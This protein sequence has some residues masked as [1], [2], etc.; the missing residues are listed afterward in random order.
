MATVSAIAPV[1]SGPASAESS[2]QDF[3]YWLRTT[4]PGGWPDAL[5]DSYRAD[6]RSRGIPVLEA[7]QRLGSIADGMSRHPEGW[8][9]LFNRVYSGPQHDSMPPNRFLVR[10][11]TSLI[12]G[13]ALDVCTGEGR[14]A[15]WLAS[16]GW[17]VTGF[18]VAERGL[19]HAGIAVRMIQS[20]EEAFRYG[21]HEWDLIVLS[22]APVYVTRPAFVAKLRTALQPGG[23]VV[24]ESFAY[25]PR[26]GPTRM[27]GLEIDPCELRH[28]FRSFRILSLDVADTVPDWGTSAAPVLRL[29]AKNI[30]NSGEGSSNRI[31][32]R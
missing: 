32:L 15:V 1:H 18:D 22:Y 5:L 7:E 29:F 2:W 17:Q 9:W 10:M 3:L 13:R 28:A 20:T 25:D 27:A 11:I 19:A 30:S 31:R 12:P 8:R 16:Q 4:A 21:C 26:L 23:V 24:I 6:L 14:N